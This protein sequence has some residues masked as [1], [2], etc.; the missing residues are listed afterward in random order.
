MPENIDSILEVT[1][2]TVGGD[3]DS[4]GATLTGKR[5]LKSNKVLNLNAPFTKFTDENED[6]AFQFEL[7]Q[8]IE[9]CSYEVNEYIFNKKW[10]VVQQELPFEEQAAADVQADVIPEAQTAAPSSPDIEA[11]QKIMDNSKVTIEVNGKKIKPRSSGRHKT[12][13]LAS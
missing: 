9:S 6:Y 7:E 10:K 1:G 4:R 3:G 2:Y 11:F 8:A 5:F 13:Q 12:T